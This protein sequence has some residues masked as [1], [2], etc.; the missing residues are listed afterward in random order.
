M[1]ATVRIRCEACQRPLTRCLCS[2]IP[3]LPHRCPVLG[4]QQ[5]QLW[6][7]EHFAD[8]PEYLARFER[9]YVLFPGAQ[10]RTVM[11][12]RAQQHI[13]DLLLVPDGTWRKARKLIHQNPVLQ[14][15]PRL[16]LTAREASRYRLRKAPDDQSLA[17]IEAIAQVLSE[18]QPE[19]DY[20][21]L[22]QPFEQL[23]QEQ[24]TAMGAQVYQRNYGS[25]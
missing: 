10:A 13:P 22:L 17:T 2:F 6:V 18:L 9:P 19:Q 15:L 7:G 3:S 4:L 20:S 25:R 12:C 8:L 16:S 24:I 1:V 23:I 11:Q 14:D 21:A 5:A